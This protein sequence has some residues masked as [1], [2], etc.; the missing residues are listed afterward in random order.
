MGRLVTELAGRLGAFDEPQREAREL[1][2]AL[3]DVPKHWPLLHDDEWIEA[4]AWKRALSAAGKRAAGAPLAYA[5]G[6]AN[7][8]GL[9]LDVDE[10]VLIPRPETELLIDLVLARCSRGVVADVGT[11]AGAIALALASEG[12][13]ERVIATDISRDALEVAEANARKVGVTNVEFVQGDLLSALGENRQPRTDRPPSVHITAAAENGLSAVVSNPP[14]ISFSEISELPASV[15]DWEPAVALFS[16]DGGM[17]ATRRLVHQ[18]ADRLRGGGLL[19]LEVDARRASLVAEL[20][21]SDRRY[22]DVSVQLDYA[23]R[24]RF[25]LATRGR[26]TMTLV[27]NRLEQR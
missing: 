13:F 19:A 1:V 3:L 18:A 16:A 12:S 6:H 21:A 4:D 20:V 14:Y 24:E 8:R 17:A 7:F 22:S 9:T 25:V 15:R 5:V 10:R 23:G 26:L 27:A 2:A 11:G